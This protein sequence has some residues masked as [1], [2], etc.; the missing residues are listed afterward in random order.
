MNGMHHH[1]HTDTYMYTQSDVLKT[2]TLHWLYLDLIQTSSW[3]YSINVYGFSFTVKPVS[4]SL[5]KLMV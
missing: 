5:G 3:G 4:S 1:M 2:H